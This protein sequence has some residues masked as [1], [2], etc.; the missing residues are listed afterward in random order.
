[1]RHLR[2]LEPRVPANQP[3][4]TAP[5]NFS[6]PG[7]RELTWGQLFSLIARRRRLVLSII[8]LVMLSVATITFLMDPE[9][10]ATT[11]LEIDPPNTEQVSLR[12]S[13]NVN[14]QVDPDYLETQAEIIRS[15]E[16]GLEVIRR[17]Q[18]DQNPDILGPAGD[19]N[20]FV[21]VALQTILRFLPEREK[22]PSQ[23]SDT[24]A[25]IILTPAESKALRVYRTR[26]KVSVMRNTDLV[27]VSFRSTDPKLAARVTN[28]LAEFYIEKNYR[29]RYETAMQ[30]TK[31]LSTQMDELQD[32]VQKS[33]DALAA[34]QNANGIVDL[35]DRQNTTTQTLEDLTR[36]ANAAKGERIQLETD[37]RTM[38]TAG[39]DALSQVRSNALIQELTRMLAD[40]SA[41][42]AESQVVYGDKNPNVRKYRN[43]L[44]ELQD[45]LREERNRIAGSVR[46][47]YNSAL[48]RERLL[49]ASIE[50]M[51]GK[52]HEMNKTVVQN[53]SL[54]KQLQVN[55]DLY[56]NL[57]TKLKEAGIAAGLRSSTIRIID[58]GRVPDRPVKPQVLVNFGI[59]FLLALI[60]ALGI[61][62][63]R[64]LMTN[65]VHAPEDIRVLTGISPIGVVPLIAAGGKIA[66]V[67]GS[68]LGLLRRRRNARTVIYNPSSMGAE[69]IRNLWTSMKFSRRKAAPRLILVTSSMA[70]EGKTTVASRLALVL[71]ETRRTCLLDADLRNPSIARSFGLKAHQGL[72]E[73]LAGQTSLESVMVQIPEAKNL[74]VI[75]GA[76]S[77]SYA[78]ELISSESM[79]QV[80]GRLAGN[81]DCV[82]I[83]SPPVL[84]FA[85]ARTLSQLVDGVLIVGR[86]GVTGSEDL[87]EALEVLERVHASL[88]GVIL[89]GVGPT[90]S[91]YRRHKRY[92]GYAEEA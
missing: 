71:A 48:A 12:D 58:R 59:G 6:Q 33:N 86:S 10:E 43:Q 37:V 42:L 39:V 34:F 9:Y 24:A 91:Y 1:V 2:Y 51:N 23:S 55:E 54:K 25:G 47:S 63:V 28:T 61:P 38:E 8:G 67:S 68:R 3:V 79:R 72:G 32:K 87:N 26:L 77:M 88:L 52:I 73:V 7:K 19:K 60:L 83:D 35:D 18:L 85:D 36:Q 50:S 49:N 75:A 11:R 90:S 4:P 27:D 17:L 92:Y 56:N 41:H 29:V 14:Q 62:L 66:R 46:A 80:V 22:A 74:T 21:Q 40:V 89:N 81:F 30:A 31:G 76:R 53:N 84:P 5:Y 20:G 13:R 65:R 44:N 15:E 45:R 82:V 78:G 57:F 69:S 64:E 16:L 70:G